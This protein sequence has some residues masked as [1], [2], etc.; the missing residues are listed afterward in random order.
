MQRVLK[1]LLIKCEHTQAGIPCPIIG[2]IRG[3]VDPP[4]GRGQALPGNPVRSPMKRRTFVHALGALPPRPT[5]MRTTGMC[6]W[7]RF[8][9]SSS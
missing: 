8:V 3:N 2:T 6:R 9:A 4:V 1:D 7:R 5:D